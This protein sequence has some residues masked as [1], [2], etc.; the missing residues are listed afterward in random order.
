MSAPLTILRNVSIF[1]CLFSARNL[2]DTTSSTLTSGQSVYYNLPYPSEG[3]TVTITVT[4]GTVVCYASLVNRQPHASN[5]TWTIQASSRT[6]DL[7]LDPQAVSSIPRS[8]VFVSVRGISS[9]N[10]FSLTSIASF[11][12]IGEQKVLLQHSLVTT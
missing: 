4:S 1:N 7:F 3:I 10:A 12:S 11:P 9:T 2:G 5:Y 6:V 8:R